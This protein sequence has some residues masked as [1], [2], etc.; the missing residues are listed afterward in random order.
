MDPAKHAPFSPRT[1]GLA[2]SVVILLSSCADRT[3]TT[4]PRSEGSLS[5]RPAATKERR[6]PPPEPERSVPPQSVTS[7]PQP[8]KAEQIIGLVR[9]G[10]LVDQGDGALVFSKSGLTRSS[11][12]GL[13][14]DAILLARLRHALKETVGVPESVSA[15]ATVRDAR[16]FLEIDDSVPA[17]TAASA[18]DAGL[19]TPG[20]IAVQ[21]RTGQGG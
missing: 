5:R 2:C 16:A 7:K 8:S 15:G 14:E 17:A 4:V 6:V 18:I 19:R 21:A 9:G 13:Y 20:I 1:L 12:S 10:R 11:R 3:P